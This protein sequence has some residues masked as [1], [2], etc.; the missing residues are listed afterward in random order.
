MLHPHASMQGLNAD[1]LREAAAVRDQAIQI[2]KPGKLTLRPNLHGGSRSVQIDDRREVQSLKTV[3]RYLNAPA[4]FLAT[5]NIELA[6]HI[7]D[8]QLKQVKDDREIVLRNDLA[9]SHQ[10]AG[11]MRL[12]GER[13]VSKLVDS[14][15]EVRNATFYDLGDYVDIS[16]VG[17]KIALRP[18]PAVD[19]ITE[20]GIRCLYSEMLTRQP[21]IEPYVERLV[22]TNGMRIR[23]AVETFKFG[24]LDEFFSQFDHSVARALEIVDTTVRKQLERAAETKVERSEQAIR[25]IFNNNQLPA[26]LLS[27]TLAALTVEEDGTAFGVLQALTRAANGARYSQRVTMQGVGAHELARLETVHCPTC[28]SSVH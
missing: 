17:Q 28:W 3:A 4:S 15:G 27:P 9:V 6:Q 20:G 14:V 5:A 12:S 26:R 25:T 16:I 2:I 18:K 10:P 8:Y 24:T 21:Q 23:S 19:D 22:C 1:A 13:I 7:V 11:T